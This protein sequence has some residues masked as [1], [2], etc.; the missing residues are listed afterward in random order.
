M[1]SREAKDFLVRQTL[2]QA[3]LEGIPVSDLETRMMYFTKGS[4]ALEDPT[5]P[6]NE[7]AAEYDSTV[8]ETK[9]SKLML[10]AY[11]RLER[12]DPQLSILWDQSVDTLLEG[13]HYLLVLWDKSAASR[14][15]AAALVKLLAKV[16]IPVVVIVPLFIVARKYFGSLPHLGSYVFLSVFAVIILAF[17]LQA[18]RPA[19]ADGIFRRTAT[20]LIKYLFG[21]KKENT[22]D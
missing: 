18:F 9:M 15:S 11:T 19:T 17:T 20:A 7:F 10:D 16:L 2:Q 12:E 5:K 22:A 21:R 13:D 14:V 1:N 6:N 4:D 8:Y 3:A